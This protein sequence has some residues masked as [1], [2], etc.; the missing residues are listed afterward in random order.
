MGQAGSLQVGLEI[1]VPS[2]NSIYEYNKQNS[3]LA[4]AD[5]TQGDFCDVICTYIWTDF[6]TKSIFDGLQH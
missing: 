6:C 4:K 1:N 2:L 5:A 3:A